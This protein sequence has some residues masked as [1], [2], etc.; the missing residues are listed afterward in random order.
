MLQTNPLKRRVW[1]RVITR[2]RIRI[3]QLSRTSLV[4]TR[5]MQGRGS[6]SGDAA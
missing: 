5:A 6:L 3:V 2:A 4:E 1:N